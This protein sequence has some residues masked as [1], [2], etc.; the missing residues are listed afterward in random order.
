M[1][2]SM[3]IEVGFQLEPQL[4]FCYMTII[5]KPWFMV[6]FL[7]VTPSRRLIAKNKLCYSTHTLLQQVN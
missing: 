2:S 5:V 4:L 7:F 6:V 3:Q 1:F